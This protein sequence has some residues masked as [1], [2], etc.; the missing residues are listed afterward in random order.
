VSSSTDKEFRSKVDN[1]IC[2]STEWQ[3]K[4]QDHPKPFG[5]VLVFPQ[6][7]A[8]SQ[9]GPGNAIGNGIEQTLP[10][11]VLFQEMNA[12]LI[13][14]VRGGGLKTPCPGFPLRRWKQASNF[15]ITDSQEY[16][17]SDNRGQNWQQ[18]KNPRHPQ[19]HGIGKSVKD[20]K[21]PPNANEGNCNKRQEQT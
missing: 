9:D 15:G 13:A 12:R 8:H 21:S 3:Q 19:C 4:Q 1:S 11:K 14:S 20:A 5:Q 16:R 17:N 6:D 18:Q 7:D 2:E 10:I